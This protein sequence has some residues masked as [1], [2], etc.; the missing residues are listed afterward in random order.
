MDSLVLAEERQEL[1]QLLDEQ[2]LAYGP[3]GAMELWNWLPREIAGNTR[4]TGIRRSDIT[5]IV[6]ILSSSASQRSDGSWPVIEFIENAIQ[7]DTT[8]A[9]AVKLRAF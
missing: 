4:V 3:M 2:T 5:T 6:R 1:I 9:S 8:S 7:M